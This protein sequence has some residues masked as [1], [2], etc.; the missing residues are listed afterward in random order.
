MMTFFSL[1]WLHRIPK[2]PYEEGLVRMAGWPQEQ[3]TPRLIVDDNRHAKA[4]ESF[5]LLRPSP[6]SE[7]LAARDLIYAH[8][9]L[10]M[11]CQSMENRRATPDDKGKENTIEDSGRQRAYY[12]ISRTNYFQRLSQTFRDGRSR[13]AL[14]CA[15]TAMIA[16]QFTGINTIGKEYSVVRNRNY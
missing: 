8:L 3:G 11:E 15:S 7:L 10:E 4:L 5:T 13:R 14:V 12:D 1:T 9:Q 6:V 16:Q 2:V